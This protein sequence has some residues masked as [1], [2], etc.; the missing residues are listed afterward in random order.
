[1][2]ESDIQVSTP[3]ICISFAQ[4][5]HQTRL[6]HLFFHL[7]VAYISQKN[8]WFLPPLQKDSSLEIVK[9]VDLCEK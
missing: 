7:V 9:D 5:F 3:I 1:M 2:Q 6:I 4:A 8:V